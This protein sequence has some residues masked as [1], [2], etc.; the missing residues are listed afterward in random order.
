MKKR[1]RITLAGLVLGAT[2]AGGVAWATIPSAVGT[3]HGCYKTSV[4]GVNDPNKGQLRVVDGASDCKTNEA[5]ISWNEKGVPGA[6]GA[7]GPAGS[8]GA[9]GDTGPVGPQGSKGEQGAT[10]PEGLKG[11]QGLQGPAGATGPAGQDGAAGPE[12]A[13]GP[14]GA[15]GPRGDTGAQGEPGIQGPPGVGGAK[16]DTG[17]QGLPGH[18]GADG[19][20][21]AAGPQGPQGPAGTG[22]VWRGEYD[23]SNAYAER[24]AVARAGSSYV[25]KLTV[26]TGCPPPGQLCSDDFAP[27]NVTYWSVLA[28]E[29]QSGP[30][31]GQGPQGDT[32]P[33]GPAGPRGPKGDT[34]PAGTGSL[35]VVNGPR[36]SNR[37]GNFVVDEATSTCPPGTLVVG[38][39]FFEAGLS[40]DVQSVRIDPAAN[41]YTARAATGLGGGTI[42]AEAH[43]LRL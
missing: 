13:V 36:E 1:T 20:P 3:I 42:I 26:P 37:L 24:D 33:A 43:C 15:I 23:P 18:R 6:V 38:G 16:G 14:A 40:A 4:A 31:G 41:S 2:L 21:G 8:S 27:P 19:A 7:T 11:D 32:G 35:S 25:A 28:Q 10:G 29:G 22:L 34:G 12:G 17:P 9:K 5:A 30:A 39:E